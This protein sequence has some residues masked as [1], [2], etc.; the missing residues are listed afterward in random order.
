MDILDEQETN[1][2]VIKQLFPSLESS[3]T[4]KRNVI[5]NVGG[6]IN[7]GNGFIFQKKQINDSVLY[8]YRFKIYQ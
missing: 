4:M 1:I 6:D 7:I 3:P 2:R 5:I 8:F